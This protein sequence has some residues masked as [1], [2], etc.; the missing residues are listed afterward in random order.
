MCMKNLILVISFYI[1]LIV[2]CKDKPASEEVKEENKSGEASALTLPEG[3]AAVTV[4]GDLGKA[5]H[6]AVNANGDLYV[7]LEE[8]KE[9]HG[10]LRLR[11]TN[12]DGKADSITGF[13]NYGG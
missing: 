10:I 13:G 4:A 3:F 8:V 12:N 11:D 6:I 7:K 5:R 1:L 9:G 2:S